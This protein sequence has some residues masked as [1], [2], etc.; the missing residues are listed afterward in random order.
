LAS[1]EPD[2]TVIKQLQ[3]I[4]DLLNAMEVVREV[5]MQERAAH[6][7]EEIRRYEKALLN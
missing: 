1:S 2:K 4:V 5:S 6:I 7:C 3:E